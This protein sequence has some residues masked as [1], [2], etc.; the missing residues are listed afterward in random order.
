MTLAV[1]PNEGRFRP[2]RW[3]GV[4]ETEGVWGTALSLSSL[5]GP[6]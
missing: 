6:S 2:R 4:K 5:P 3:T 1:E